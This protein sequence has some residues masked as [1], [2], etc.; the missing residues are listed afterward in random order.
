MTRAQSLKALRYAEQIRLG[1]SK[2]KRAVRAGE[3]TVEAALSVECC[4]GMCIGQLLE[5]QSK[6]GPARTNGLLSRLQISPLRSV[7]KLTDRQ[8]GLVAGL[9]VD[10]PRRTR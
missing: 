4:Q 8:R 7:A 1:R 3:M 5:A 6:W 10:P 9:V 2:V